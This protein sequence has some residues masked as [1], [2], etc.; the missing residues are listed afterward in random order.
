MIVLKKIVRYI[1]KGCDNESD[2]RS[3]LRRQFI[4]DPIEIR[5]IAKDAHGDFEAVVVHEVTQAEK[6]V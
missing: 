1:V 3:F 5:S 6:G 4:G 2:M